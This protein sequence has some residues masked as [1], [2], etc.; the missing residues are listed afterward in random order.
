MPIIMP[1]LPVPAWWQLLRP[2][3]RLRATRLGLIGAGLVLFWLLAAL[4]AP[5]LAPFPPHATLRPYA[6]P[7][8]ANAAGGRFWCGTDH[9]GRDIL[10]RILYGAR[11]VL[12]YAPLA[13]ATAYS[14]GI[15]LGLLAGYKGG[16][17]DEVVSRLSDIILSFPVL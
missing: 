7:G 8:T 5:L 2:A 13:T 14:V 9:L 12:G 1:S 17:I 15:P 3:G 11:T 16:W 10:S 6:P 4:L